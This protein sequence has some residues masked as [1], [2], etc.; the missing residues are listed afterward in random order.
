MA[1]AKGS[2]LEWALALLR[3]PGERHA[4][5]QRPLPEGVAEL[6]GV[7]SEPDDAALSDIAMRWGES[8]ER[9]REAAR[10]YARE[11]LFQPQADAYRV[12]GLTP[13]ATPEAIKSHHRLLQR[14]LHPDRQHAGDDRVFAGRVNTAWNQ[15]SRRFA[16]LAPLG[17]SVQTAEVKGKTVYRLRVNAGS[18]NQASDL[19]GKLKLAGENCFIAR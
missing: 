1:G 19:C 10:F 11:I 15:L 5:R 6:L 9:L 13:T 16:Y 2:A 4:L 14:W 18:A 12:L 7:A 17:K 8:P 3:A